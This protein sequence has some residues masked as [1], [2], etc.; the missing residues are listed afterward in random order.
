MPPRGLPGEGREI[1]PLLTVEEN[2][3]SGFA[4]LPRSGILAAL[5]VTTNK[6]VWRH[7]TMDQCY[8]GVVATA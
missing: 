2:L 3:K 1:F 7:R 5:D 8:S 4:P 6:L